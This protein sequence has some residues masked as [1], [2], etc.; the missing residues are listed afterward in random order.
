MMDL[1]LI[2][3]LSPTD[4]H[5]DQGGE[6]RVYDTTQVS[7]DIVRTITISNNTR[8]TWYG[9]AQGTGNY[10]LIFITE[11]GESLVRSLLLASSDEKLSVS[12]HS[13]L[14]QSNTVT[15][16]HILSLVG[17]SGNITLNGTVQIDSD[18]SKVKGHILEENIFLGSKGNIRGIPAL[19]VHS[20]DVEA[21]HAARI[22][23][24][25]DEKLYY[26]RARGIPKDDA[27]VMMIESAV[28]SLFD[29]LPEEK[30]EEI[31]KRVFQIF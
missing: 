19:L 20:D 4:L 24:V 12:I 6:V 21:G 22:E 26:L 28:L 11:S 17:E 3:E 23:R 31:M 8:L 13:T 14:K 10:S 5:Y 7:S 30:K 9:L 27:I 25:S 1:L 2:N 29:G 16:I 15:N 18:I